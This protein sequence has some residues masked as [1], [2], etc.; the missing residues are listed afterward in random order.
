MHHVRL[1]LFWLKSCATVLQVGSSGRM[2][3]LANKHYMPDGR[4]LT[5]ER[6]AGF[7]LEVAFSCVVAYGLYELKLAMWSEVEVKNVAPKRP[8]ATKRTQRFQV[9]AKHQQAIMDAVHDIVPRLHQ[10]GY[11]IV[12]AIVKQAGHLACHDLV[13]ELRKIG[14]RCHGHYSCELKLRTSPSNRLLMRSDC[15]GLFQV[16][17]RRS[18]HWLGQLVIVAEVTTAGDFLRSKAELILRDQPRADASNLWGYQGRPVGTPPPP[19]PPVSNPQAKAAPKA[20]PKAAPRAAPKAAPQRLS[21]PSWSVVWG[22]VAKFSATFTNEQVAKLK[23][24]IIACG[25]H[26]KHRITHA[27]RIVDEN[28]EAPLEWSEGTHWGRGVT[29]GQ[30]R[31]RQGGGVAPIVV[32]RSSLEAYHKHLAHGGV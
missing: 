15:A 1:S 10:L 23:D 28:Q 9:A 19:P 14:S 21:L 31:M 30:G 12:N 32:R 6:I 26:M 7:A 22:A 13:L 16:A 18:K 17:V 24:F 20:V 27:S 2:D 8:E 11:G 29:R 5:P 4:L 3:P 25:P